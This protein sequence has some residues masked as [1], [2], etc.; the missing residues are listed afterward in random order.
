MFPATSGRTRAEGQ[1]TILYLPTMD[2]RLTHR[3]L[4]Q[5]ENAA[6]LGRDHQLVRRGLPVWLVLLSL[7]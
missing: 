2:E 1:R 6:A 3:D 4:R 5:H 7:R